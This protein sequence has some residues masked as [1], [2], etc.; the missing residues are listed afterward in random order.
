MKEASHF[1]SEHEFREWFEKNLGQFG[2]RSIMLS[3][4][5]CPDFVVIMESGETK[6][7]EAELIAINFRYHKHSPAKVDYRFL[8][9][10]VHANQI[11]IMNTAAGFLSRKAGLALANALFITTNALVGVAGLSAQLDADL[12]GIMAR[13]DALMQRPDFLPPWPNDPKNS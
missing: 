9:L 1:D 8:S 5:V 10:H 13:M 4:E 11:G 2:I 7:V 3:Q 6:K 12:T